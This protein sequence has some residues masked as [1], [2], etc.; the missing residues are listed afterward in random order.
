M[1]RM[2]CIGITLFALAAGFTPMLAAAQATAPA[3]SAPASSASTADPASPDAD[4]TTTTPANGSKPPLAGLAKSL[5]AEGINLRSGIIDQ[6]AHNTTGGIYQGH[7]NV[8][9]FNIGAD[10]DLDKMIGLTGGSFH[11]TVYRDYGESLNKNVTG[12][13]TKQQYIY[14]NEFYRWHLGLFAYEQKLLDDKLD[15][16]AGRLGT[17]TYYGHLVTNCQFESADT[18]GEPRILVSEAGFSLLPSATWGLNVKYKPTAHTYIESGVFEVNP[19]TSASNGLDFSIANATGITVPV[20]WAWAKTDPATIRYPFELKVGAF[21]ST[22]PLTDP[23]FNTAGRSKALY[24]GTALTVNSSRDGVYIMGDR[25]VWRPND[26]SA[27]SFNIF[28]GI[29]QQ[30]DEAEIMRQQVYTGFVWTSPFAALPKDTLNF[31]VSEFELTPREREFLRDAR[32]KKGG[33]G[34]N[35]AHQT[36][37]ELTYGWHVT[38]G[39]ELMPSVQYIV[40][41]DNSSI[42]TTKIFPKN[43]FAFGLSLRLDIGSMLGF[44]RTV[45]GD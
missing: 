42:T 16:T 4:D 5:K 1:N 3:S 36:A 33:H 7:T 11:F 34:S 35:A 6:Y 44:E 40:H 19:T 26:A 27:Q 15:I 14:K 28:G 8:G 37:F 45:G 2:T 30:L 32:I 20:E 10:F 23:Y 21:V 39:L 41:P 22:A 9:Q 17:T 18:C 43:M 24:G 13:F 38:R 29:V 25:V 31:S 12:T